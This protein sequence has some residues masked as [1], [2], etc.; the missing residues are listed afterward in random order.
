[1]QKSTVKKKVQKRNETVYCAHLRDAM[2][3]NLPLRANRRG[4]IFNSEGERPSFAL[5]ELFRYRR[6]G[7]HTSKLGKS[8]E[9]ILTERMS[10]VSIK[11]YVKKQTKNYH[12]L[13]T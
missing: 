11:H 3:N 6:M 13:K 7:C 4:V 10:F 8:L 5:D 2:R 9:L 12:Q 1:M